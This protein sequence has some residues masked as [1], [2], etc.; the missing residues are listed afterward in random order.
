MRLDSKII[1]EYDFTNPRL[2]NSTK[3]PGLVYSSKPGRRATKYS[4]YDVNY[5]FAYR[6]RSTYISRGLVPAKRFCSIM[7]LPQLRKLLLKSKF[8]FVILINYYKTKYYFKHSRKIIQ[9]YDFIV[10]S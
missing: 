1:H 3:F 4:Y 8:T 9:E 5:R 6:M 2:L 7:E 10:L